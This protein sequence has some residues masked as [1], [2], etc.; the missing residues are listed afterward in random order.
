MKPAAPVSSAPQISGFLLVNKPAGPTS[1]DMIRRIKKTLR[2]AKIGHAGTLDPLASGLL[3]VLLGRATK[4]QDRFMAMEKTYV[5]KM[6]LGVQTD[7]GDLAGAPIQEKPV[8]NLS[9]DEVKKILESFQGPRMQI[10]P[11]YSALKKDGQ[12]LY[13]LARKGETV[14]RPPRP[15]V[16]HEIKLLDW[17]SPVIHFSVRCSSGTYVRTLVEDF[18]E[19]LGSCAVTIELIRSKIGPYSI[20][21]AIQGDDL[22]NQTAEQ[23]ARLTRAIEK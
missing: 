11:M 4:L 7:T 3:V 6:K 14:E 22:P 21:E 13:K 8:P 2:G 18:G 17:T 5:C 12:P 23:I 16:L 1:Y 9:A 15:I 20:D 19:A 10:P